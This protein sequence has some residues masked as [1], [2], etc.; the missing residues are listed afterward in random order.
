LL[1]NIPNGRLMKHIV[2]APDMRGRGYPRLSEISGIH[3][4]VMA[5]AQRGPDSCG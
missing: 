2:A 1:G 5:L 4:I 3:R